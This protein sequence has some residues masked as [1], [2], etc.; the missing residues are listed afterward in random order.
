MAEFYKALRKT[1]R[2]QNM[3][4]KFAAQW[5]AATAWQHKR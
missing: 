3:A 2:E 1:M 5:R 4:S